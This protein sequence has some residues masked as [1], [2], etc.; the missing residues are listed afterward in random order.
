MEDLHWPLTVLSKAIDYKNMTGA[1]QNIG[2]SQPQISR[3]ITKIE[4]SLGLSLI[5]RSSPRASSWTP[6]ARSLAEIYQQSSRKLEHALETL[7]ED[8]FP[9][10]LNI[11]TLEGLS[12]LAIKYGKKVLEQT[13]LKQLHINVFDQNE[14]ESK[15][16]MADL[17]LIFTSRSIGQKKYLYSK[18]IGHQSF[19]QFKGTGPDHVFSPFEHSGLKREKA[20]K[21]PKSF[22]SN[23]LALRSEW[24]NR[25]G[26]KGQ[27]PSTVKKGTDSSLKG[28]SPVL[29]IAQDYLHPKL[30]SY[31]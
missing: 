12:D 16:L 31:L 8:H 25:F 14:M 9:Q 28:T 20:Q 10:T 19:T 6:Q 11:G 17:D 27:I 29:V 1:S 22:I 4:D 30:W 15:Y 23:S 3:L 18:I 13:G 21:L 7:K 24:L 2:L 5:D 26:G